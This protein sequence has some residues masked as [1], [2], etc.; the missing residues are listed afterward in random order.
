M[1]SFYR[2]TVATSWKLAFA[3][4]WLWPLAFF[5]SFLGIATTFRIFLDLAPKNQSLVTTITDMVSSDFL[6]SNFIGWAESFYRIPWAS[7]NISDAP[8]LALILLLLVVIIALVIMVISS[9][10]GLIAGI[11]GVLNNKRISAFNS[12][13]LGLNKFWQLFVVHFFYSLLYTVFLGIIILP[14][15]LLFEQM[16]TPLRLV[17]ALALYFII[18]P[19][20]VVLDILVR[21]TVMYIALRR[22]T[23]Q[24]A[25][26]QAYALF[27]ANWLISLE[28]AVMVM[29]LLI[30]LAFIVGLIVQTLL[31]L[32]VFF[33]SLMP[34]GT[35]LYEVAGFIGL[36][37]IVFILALSVIVFTT[38]YMAIW[39]N[40]F[41]RLESEVHYSK[42]HRAVRFAPWLHKKIV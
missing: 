37:C 38:F 5:T 26:N 39:T 15:V 40:I 16:T 36:A 30:M 41:E 20:L 22:A 9:E 3:Q 4:R 17:V 27:K 14:I 35:L 2:D 10:A 34:V 8:L 18:V 11:S 29:A 19:T 24:G 42:I 28:T 7:I 1:K 21:Y 6:T 12:L 32:F 33:A 13:Q 25:F 31:V 23:L